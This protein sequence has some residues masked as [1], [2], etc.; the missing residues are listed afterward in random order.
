M[1]C[2]YFRYQSAL[3]TSHSIRLMTGNPKAVQGF[4]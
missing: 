4:L 1:E 2:V 3:T